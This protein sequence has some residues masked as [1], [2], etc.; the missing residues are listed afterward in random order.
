MNKSKWFISY[1]Y[2][3]IPAVIKAKWS[4]YIAKK[5]LHKYVCS[6]VSN[7]VSI[8]V[9][10]F[11]CDRPAPWSS[12]QSFWQLIVRSRV[13]FPVLPL[14]FFLEG[15]D[16]HGDHGLGSLVELRLTPLLVLHIHVSPSTS[17]G[18]RNCASWA[19]QPEKSATLRPQPGGETTK[20]IRDMWWHWPKKLSV[21]VLCTVT[22]S[23]RNYYITSYP[24]FNC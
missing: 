19:S 9:C 14:G 21:T 15:E 1:S 2:K 24:M 7:L 17:S 10:Y 12:G 11:V 16:S 6:G 23:V 3:S 18:Q 22:G 4:M 13:R 20:S 8:F 5:N